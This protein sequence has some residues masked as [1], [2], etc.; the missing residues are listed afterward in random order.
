MKRIDYEIKVKAFLGGI[1]ECGD[2]GMVREYD[3]RCFLALIDVLGHGASAR[4][5]A[6]LAEEYLAIHYQKELETVMAGLHEYLKGSRGA[7]VSLCCVDVNR[8]TLE[9]IGIGNITVRI[10]GARPIRFVSQDGIVG[11]GS[12]SPCVK[13]VELMPGDILLMHSDGIREHFDV[14]ECAKIFAESAENIATAVLNEFRNEND[15]ASCI[16]L[17]YSR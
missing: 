17:K 7:V 15:D 8:G 14:T 1:S 4:T 2:I 10:F 13:S 11:F 3:D 16:V 5:V 12:I 6:L 9:H